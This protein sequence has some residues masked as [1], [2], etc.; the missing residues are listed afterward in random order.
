MYN[1]INQLANFLIWSGKNKTRPAYIR[2]GLPI[3]LIALATLLKL[4]FPIAI[5]FKSPHL[6]YFGIVCLSAIMGGIGPA[7]MASII[8][9]VVGDYYF[10]EQHGAGS[11]N[12][13]DIAE[14]I[15]FL[16]ECFLLTI[17]GSIVRLA[18]QQMRRNQLLFKAMVEKGSEVI[19]MTNRE[20]KRVY[21]SAAIEKVTGYTVDEFLQMKTLAL[22][23]PEEKAELQALVDDLMKHPGANITYVRRVRH[24]DGHW[25][26]IENTVTN[27][28]EDESVQAM[29]A[30]FYNVT[31][32][33]LMEQKKDDFISIASHELKTPL[34][35]LKASLQLLDRVKDDPTVV[36]V[37][38]L[39]AQSNRSMDK[40]TELVDE[41]LNASRVTQGQLNLNR[42]A[43]SIG[44]LLENCCNHIRLLGKNDLVLQGDK[45]LQVFADENRV[46]QVL[47]NLV[48]NAIKYA[49][50][51]KEIFVIIE[52]EDNMAKISV[53]DTGPGIPYEKQ[54]HIFD[55]YYRAEYGGNQNQGL[56]LG[57]YIS[58]GI[59]K[60][61]GGQIGV[62]S[63]IGK[64]STFWFTL[65][66][67]EG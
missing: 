42:V 26:W 9:A 66:L 8:S 59:I 39:I 23:D 45:H 2:Y 25:L 30:N 21:C 22:A 67:S 12:R 28:L 35:T 53:K 36:I 58:A 4:Q 47:V 62:N 38:K 1:K 65:P 43:I 34:T 20:G 18:Y 13:D 10:L 52:K 11:F 3:I 27:L 37:P 46:E 7:I 55:R 54:Q 61:H 16:S 31:D 33:V 6:L 29:V 14:A 5:G 41:L 57:L 24:K 63:E 49:P 44:A 64:G 51:S 60:K 56:G 15:F 17:L 50:A 19:V 32:R 40:I 48:N